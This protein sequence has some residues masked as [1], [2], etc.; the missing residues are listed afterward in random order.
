MRGALQCADGEED[1]DERSRSTWAE[2]VSEH[3]GG[4]PDD[5]RRD[6]RNSGRVSGRPLLF[7]CRWAI[8]DF[9]WVQLCCPLSF[10]YCV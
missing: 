3:K 10:S 6:H 2:V 9:L 1:R 5:E 7:W 4:G 8:V